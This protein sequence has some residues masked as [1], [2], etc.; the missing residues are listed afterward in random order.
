[1]LVKI[2]YHSNSFT[3]Q[4]VLHVE[5]T[6]IGHIGQEVDDG[7]DGHGNANGEGQVPTAKQTK[8]QSYHYR[9]IPTSQSLDSAMPF[10]PGM[11]MS[12][13]PSSFAFEIA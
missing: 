4:D 6:V 8:C 12:V 10:S 2:L 11:Q 9:F 7:D 13:L 3:R 1:M 5:H